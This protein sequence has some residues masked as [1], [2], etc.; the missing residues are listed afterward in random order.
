[1]SNASKIAVLEAICV[2]QDE[3]IMKLHAAF[4]GLLAMIKQAQEFAEKPKI[5]V[6]GS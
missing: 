3:Q 6:V 4:S 1:M 2:Q 5:K